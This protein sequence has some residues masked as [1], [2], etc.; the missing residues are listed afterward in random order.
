MSKRI[1][2]KLEIKGNARQLQEFLH[3][4]NGEFSVFDFNRILPM[5]K[6][7]LINDDNAV[8]ILK[9]CRSVKK[10]ARAIEDMGFVWLLNYRPIR[11]IKRAS[12]N[13]RE[14]GHMTWRDWRLKKWGTEY[15]AM[16]VRVHYLISGAENVLTIWFTSIDSPPEGILRA[17]CE[18]FPGLDIRHSVLDTY[19]I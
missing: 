16:D 19:I 9:E 18:L 15:L 2:N 5:P 7:L 4:V 13:K 1:V 14:F 8:K 6:K 11:N 3:S 10:A 12:Q 17:L